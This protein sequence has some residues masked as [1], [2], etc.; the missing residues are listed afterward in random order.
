MEDL[1][2]SVGYGVFCCLIDMNQLC[3]DTQEKILSK[4][5]QKVT[6]CMEIVAKYNKKKKKKIEVFY[7]RLI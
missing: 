2:Q 1:P 5:M 7:Y 6:A 4:S 3:S